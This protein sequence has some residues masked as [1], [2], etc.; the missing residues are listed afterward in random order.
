MAW[1]EGNIDSIP[2][3]FSDPAASMGCG[4]FIVLLGKR[5]DVPLGDIVRGATPQQRSCIL[6]KRAWMR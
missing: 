1:N 3:Y 2:R 5:A 6:E 4:E